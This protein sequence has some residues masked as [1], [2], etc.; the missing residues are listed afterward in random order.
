MDSW[1]LLKHDWINLLTNEGVRLFHL[2]D[3]LTLFCLSHSPIDSETIHS[4]LRSELYMLTYLSISSLLKKVLTFF[5]LWHCTLIC[6]RIGGWTKEKC[7]D[8]RQCYD[9]FENFA[10]DIFVLLPKLEGPTCRRYYSRHSDV[11]SS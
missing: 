6:I 7:I 5:A 1:H 10:I 11:T 8:S 3:L 9:L 4:G 2:G